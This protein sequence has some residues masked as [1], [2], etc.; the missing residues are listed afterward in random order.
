MNDDAGAHAPIAGFR[1]VTETPKN[2]RARAGTREGRGI[3]IRAVRVPP[4]TRR[5][6][7]VFVEVEH[8]GLRLTFAVA[9]LRGAA[10][11]VRPPRAPD[12]TGEGVW[13]PKRERDRI[14]EAILAAVALDSDAS[15]ALKARY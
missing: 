5:T 2:T 8:L 12:G 10:L 11:Q 3:T 14:G 9:R 15:R 13:M 6:P 7:L 4:G 1:A